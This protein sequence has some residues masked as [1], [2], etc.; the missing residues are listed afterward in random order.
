MRFLFDNNLPPQLARALHELRTREIDV[1]E[2]V[3]LRDKFQGAGP[4]PGAAADLEWLPGLD[5]QWFVMSQD[6]FKKNKGL[7]RKAIAAAGH[8]VYSL[9]PQWTSQQYWPKVARLLLWWPDLLGHA[10]RTAGGIYR[11]PWQRTSQGRL[12]AM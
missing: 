5:G 2:V 11:V 1:S 6:M 8:V 4:V 12:A 7:E 10:R 3:A 9:D